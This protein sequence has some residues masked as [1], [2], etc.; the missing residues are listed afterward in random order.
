MSERRARRDSEVSDV[1]WVG[2]DEVWPECA[3]TRATQHAAARERRAS[4]RQ[5][6]KKRTGIMRVPTGLATFIRRHLS[7][8]RPRRGSFSWS[9]CLESAQEG[10]PR[11]SRTQ[12]WL[13]F[14]DE[15]VEHSTLTLCTR[16]CA[17]CM[18]SRACSLLDALFN[19]VPL[20]T[21]VCSC[22]LVS[23]TRSHH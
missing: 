5:K 11:R 18:C 22:V 17:S 6:N 23:A 9:R 14:A 19:S 10:P 4:P 8:R 13:G 20:K 16:I 2:T 3:R 21:G 15:G 12:Q 1:N 7:V